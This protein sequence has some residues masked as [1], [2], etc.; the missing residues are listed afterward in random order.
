MLGG[1]VVREDEALLRS[2]YYYF[3]SLCGS[4]LQPSLCL[5]GSQP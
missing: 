4:V 5:I 1:R 3:L 2:A